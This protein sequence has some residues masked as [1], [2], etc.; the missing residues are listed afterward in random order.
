MLEMVHKSSFW[1]DRVAQDCCQPRLLHSRTVAVEPCGA[2]RGWGQSSVVYHNAR[3]KLLFV[4]WFLFCFGDLRLVL[5]SEWVLAMFGI[6][7]ETRLQR[8]G[9]SPWPFAALL[10]GGVQHIWPPGRYGWVASME[11]GGREHEKYPICH[12]VLS[13]SNGLITVG[14]NS[15]WIQSIAIICHRMRELALQFFCFLF[16]Q[17]ICLSVLHLG[18]C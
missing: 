5:K 6:V 3:T 4:D 16:Q 8:A 2:H 10:Q 1:H 13:L 7:S 11:V 15:G 18:C 12:N 17:K 9:V 14:K